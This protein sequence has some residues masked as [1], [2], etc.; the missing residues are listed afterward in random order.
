MA[1][2]SGSLSIGLVTEG[3]GG[4]GSLDRGELSSVSITTKSQRVRPGNKASAKIPKDWRAGCWEVP[5]GVPVDDVLRGEEA[6][7]PSP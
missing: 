7:C 1:V 2:A 3:P 5:V 6:Q 4:V